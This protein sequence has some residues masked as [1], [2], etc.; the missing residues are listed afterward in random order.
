MGQENNLRQHDFE[1]KY[2]ELTVE[3]VTVQEQKLVVE[4]RRRTWLAW[5]QDQRR[6][7]MWAAPLPAAP[8]KTAP[9]IGDS[10]YAGVYDGSTLTRTHDGAHTAGAERR[11]SDERARGPERARGTRRASHTQTTRTAQGVCERLR[12][13]PHSESIPQ[14]EPETADCLVTTN[15]DCCCHCCSS[16][17][18]ASMRFLQRPWK[19]STPVS[20]LHLELWR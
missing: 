13:R 12:A 1:R 4:V 2:A 3:R 11:P 15:S 18:D 17:C 19:N 20:P 7:V 6:E 16:I 5:R 10:A 14:E 8:W 9:R